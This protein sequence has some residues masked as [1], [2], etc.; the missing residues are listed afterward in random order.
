MHVWN[1]RRLTRLAL[2]RKASAVAQGVGEAL[3]GDALRGGGEVGF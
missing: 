2:E 3:L 1:L